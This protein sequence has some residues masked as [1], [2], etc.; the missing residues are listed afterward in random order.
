MN[1][2]IVFSEAEIRMYVKRYLGWDDT[3]EPVLPNFL[4]EVSKELGRL[5]EEL[6]V[7]KNACMQYQ[8]AQREGWDAYHELVL[9]MESLEK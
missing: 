7:Y 4:L 9:R 2:Y 3:K 5:R 1:P 8:K 6:R